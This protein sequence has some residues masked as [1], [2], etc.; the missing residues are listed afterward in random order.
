[1]PVEPEYIHALIG[2]FNLS[3]S[4]EKG[5][6]VALVW[7]II[8]HPDWKYEGEKYDADIAIVVLT[9]RVNLSNQIQLVCLPAAYHEPLGLGVVVGWG[10]SNVNVEHVDTPNKLELPVVN[11]SYCYT[12]FPKLSIASSH[13]GFC[14]GF[15]NKGRGSCTGDSGGGFYMKDPNGHFW[16]VKGIVSGSLFDEKFGCDVNSFGLYTNVAYFRIWIDEETNRTSDAV[17]KT[18]EVQC[19]NIEG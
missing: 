3:N 15:E 4:N 2:R 14:A 8:L 10:K 17:L 1:M 5:S 18:V 12:R 9:Q 19:E 7:D 13:R 16:S 11:A 6:K